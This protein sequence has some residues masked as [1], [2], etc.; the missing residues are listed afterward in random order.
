MKYLFIG[1]PARSGTT[2]FA[3]LINRHPQVALGIER[4]KFLYPGASRYF[5][6]PGVIR[7]LLY[8]GAVRRHDEIG[9]QLFEADRFFRFD[10]SETNIGPERLG[11]L[12]AFQQKFET[13]LYRGD[14]IPHIMRY[15]QILDKALPGCRFI[16]MYRDVNRICSSWNQRAQNS[17]DRWAEENNFTKAVGAINRELGAAVQLQ[18]TSPDR[19]LIV[20]YENIFGSAAIETMGRILDWLG[21]AHSPH[22][23]KA[24]QGNLV[25]AEQIRSKPLLELDGQQEFIQAEINW[26]VINE[27]EAAAI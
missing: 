19:C 16:I 5:L 20:R 26:S 23:M 12:E 6:Y 2:G 24:V 4:Y 13:S 8:L 7:R 9:P 15:R 25:K 22:L 1:G 18:K 27:A 3:Q 14:K 10:P 21:L 17:K 11:P